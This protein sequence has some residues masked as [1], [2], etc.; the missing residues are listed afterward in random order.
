MF[1]LF[2]INKYLLIN[3]VSQSLRHNNGPLNTL[4]E[5]LDE[6]SVWLALVKKSKIAT[7]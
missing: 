4:T 1:R 6:A 7:V 2:A 3:T 5:N